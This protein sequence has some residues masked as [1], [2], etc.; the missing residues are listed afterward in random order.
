MDRM[1]WTDRMQ[2]TYGTAR[3][4]WHPR[5]IDRLNAL[6]GRAVTHATAVMCQRAVMA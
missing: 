1:D 6:R 3:V 4:R 2:W 5:S